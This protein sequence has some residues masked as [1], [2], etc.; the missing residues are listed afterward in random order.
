M[1]KQNILTLDAQ[2][3]GRSS[4][5]LLLF[6]SSYS[7]SRER[8]TVKQTIKQSRPSPQRLY[9]KAKMKHK[10]SNKK[11]SSSIR[12]SAEEVLTLEKLA[13]SS[14]KQ[15][16]GQKQS[17]Q[18]QIEV[19]DSTDFLKDIVG[20]EDREDISLDIYAFPSVHKQLDV[21]DELDSDILEAY[22]TRGSRLKGWFK[23][24]DSCLRVTIG[25]KTMRES[26]N[27]N[28]K[29]KPVQGYK[30]LD[31]SRKINAQN[32][33]HEARKH[34]Q[35]LPLKTNPKSKDLILPSLNPSKLTL[36][37]LSPSPHKHLDPKLRTSLEF[38]KP[39]H[40][41][42]LQPGPMQKL[43]SMNATGSLQS[44]TER[45]KLGQPIMYN[46]D[47]LDPPPT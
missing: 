25:D 37:K 15:F 20:V 38:T 39:L 11:Y 47:L 7:T 13:K 41:S 36:S 18:Q 2:I 21:S 40:G 16:F 26:I 4:K 19:D 14:I 32:S 45:R 17:K 3:Q 30:L 12:K 28:K 5:V 1:R 27:I 29:S 43:N 10:F 6:Y 24:C 8:G 22:H 23:L 35:A 31:S 9:E 42:K 34:S 46:S 44:L 33:I